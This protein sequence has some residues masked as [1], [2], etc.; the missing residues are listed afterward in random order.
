LIDAAGGDRVELTVVSDHGSGGSS[1]KVL[2]LN[3]AL[4]G[5]GLCTLREGSAASV[6]SSALK[7]VALSG[8]PPKLRERVFRASGALLPSLLES[9]ARFSAIDFDR[10]RA[11]SE[12][13]N[14]FPSVCL[15]V[16]GREP[17]GTVR[18]ADVPHVRRE[19]E[20]ALR[21]IHDPWSGQPVVREVWPRE[22]LFSGPHV[23][24]A[25]DLL[26]ELHLDRGYSYA[27]M[28][29]AS[30]PRG[31]GAWRKLDCEEHL[32]KKGRS[33]P[34]AHR[35]RGLYVAAGPRI[36]STGEMDARIAD[37]TATLLARMDVAVPP[38]AA[39]R[40]LWEILAEAATP[41]RQRTLPLAPS[42]RAQPAGDDARV[43][44]RL[45]ALGY[46]D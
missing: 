28:P 7:R 4:A 29:T 34:G 8:L 10:T 21:A 32:G 44:D 22:E 20:A 35:P 2:Y 33:L 9:R 30:A 5:A 37:A 11:F 3:R 46:V 40:V 1:D 27:L 12:E 25:P 15:N 19:V 17:R 13:L 6:L 23:E 26:L 14:Y 31:T 43:I 45:R 41:D 18:P 36:A 24:R 42:R 16:T 38:D 39:G